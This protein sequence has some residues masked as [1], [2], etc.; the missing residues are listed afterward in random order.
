VKKEK[1]FEGSW[2]NIKKIG[3]GKMTIKNKIYLQNYDENHTLL[4][5]NL[6][7]FEEQNSKINLLDSSFFLS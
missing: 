2:K 7:N 4:Y 1:I 3:E 5:S 6:K